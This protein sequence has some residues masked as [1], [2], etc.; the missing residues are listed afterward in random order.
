MQL[1]GSSRIHSGCSVATTNS[2][3]LT[4]IDSPDGTIKIVQIPPI[5]WSEATRHSRLASPSCQRPT[6]ARPGR[7][8]GRQAIRLSGYERG[9]Q[10]P[11]R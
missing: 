7:R 9:I 10:N 3:S 4:L 6:C 2:R 11:D 1:K 8:C 5:P